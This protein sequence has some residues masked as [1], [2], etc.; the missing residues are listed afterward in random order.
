MFSLLSGACGGSS[1]SAP[2]L[3]G[4]SS[5]RG[6]TVSAVDGRPISGV[7]VKVGERAAVSDQLGRFELTDLPEGA[8][9]VTLSGASIV[10]RRINV[11]L[12]AAA[13][14]T[15]IPAAFD[16]DAFDEMFRA[17]GQL[18]RWMSQPAL[19][20]VASAMNYHAG[21][22]EL[23]QA[24]S[25]QLTDEEVG[26]LVEHLTEGLALLT[27][28]RFTSFASVQVERPSSGTQV[29]TLRTG[30][31]VVGRYRGVQSLSNTI[32]FGRWSNSGT[33]EVT[34]GAIYLDRNF[35]A[36]E[37]ARRLVRIH[38]LGHALGYLHVTKRVS[39]MNPAIGPQ[40][41]E[42]DRQA[43]IVAFNRRPGNQSPDSDV[44]EP[45]PP[46]GGLFGTQACA[47]LT[48]ARQ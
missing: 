2:A 32:A 47:R 27:G 23:F 42:F 48:L 7:A 31:I 25:E 43:S 5:Y 33:A 45:K 46:T 24:S 21:G 19:V 9:T 12:P 11:A 29:D 40:P 18:Q 17:T 36:E 3:S 30:F 1:P 34:G 4:A 14:E 37:P 8:V 16:L 22:S 13:T 15:L 35:D 41:T 6:E 38:E 20:V 44:L 26:L 10:E 39:I 28:G